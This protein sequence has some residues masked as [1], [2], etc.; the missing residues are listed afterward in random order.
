MASD[1]AGASVAMRW[2]LL[3]V[4]L[5][6]SVVYGVAFI[7]N[8]WG[9]QDL[10]PTMNVKNWLM[11][12]IAYAIPYALFLLLWGKRCL[13]FGY[14]FLLSV[15]YLIV[16]WDTASFSVYVW[17][18]GVLDDRG[19]EPNLPI[20]YLVQGLW[21]VSLALCA[22]VLKVYSTHDAK[23]VRSLRVVLG[24]CGIPLAFGLGSLVLAA[25]LSVGLRRILGVFLLL[26]MLVAFMCLVQ[27]IMLLPFW[28]NILTALC[29]RIWGMHLQRRQFGREEVAMGM[30][31]GG[32][33]SDFT[34]L[35]SSE[36]NSDLNKWGSAMRREVHQYSKQRRPRP[37]MR[38]TSGALGIGLLVLVVREIASKDSGWIGEI[39][40]L[41]Q[42]V[43]DSL[44]VSDMELVVSAFLLLL[45]C[46]ISYNVH[47][48]YLDYLE[49]I[50]R[51]FHNHPLNEAKLEIPHG[52]L[53]RSATDADR[54]NESR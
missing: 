12:F 38:L 8:W 41:I 50:D 49:R 47:R 14:G 1:R 18:F 22:V 3:I 48:F 5:E 36:S 54:R 24:F 43:R 27:G 21:L 53:M 39:P 46:I 32:M 33:H 17:C 26:L 28:V 35:D 51:Y 10:I 15:S 37:L 16:V 45:I 9:I 23:S 25:E 7:G 6:V 4:A 52:D 40:R 42:W 31:F 34:Y 13:F 30:Y 29:A 2:N 44:H 20:P 19:G 11:L